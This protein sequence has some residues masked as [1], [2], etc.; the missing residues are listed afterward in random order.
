MGRDI[1][2]DSSPYRNSI[3]D[4]CEAVTTHKTGTCMVCIERG[5][6]FLKTMPTFDIIRDDK[7][8]PHICTDYGLRSMT[9]T[10]T[11]L[12]DAGILVGLQNSDYV[13]KA[14]R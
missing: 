6:E 11:H 9:Q 4:A 13:S 7:G 12:L 5:I 2:M 8:I 3:C 1:R 10:E 14:G